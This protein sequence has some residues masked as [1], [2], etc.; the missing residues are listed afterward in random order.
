MQNPIEEEE[1]RTLPSI[2]STKRIKRFGN[3]W[4]N[5]NSSRAKK[6]NVKLVQQRVIKMGCEKCGKTSGTRF[7]VQNV[8]LNQNEVKKNG[9]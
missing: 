4:C 9:D 1:K 8:F 7:F 6:Q 3:G 5:T 2:R